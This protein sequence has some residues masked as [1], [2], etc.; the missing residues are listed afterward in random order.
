M[1]LESMT[2]AVLGRIRVVDGLGKQNRLFDAIIRPD[3]P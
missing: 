1:S 3:V 2:P